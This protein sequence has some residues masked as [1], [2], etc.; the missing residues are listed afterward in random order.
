MPRLLFSSTV[1]L[2]C[3]GT[4]VTYSLADDRS[5]KLDIDYSEIAKKSTMLLSD[6]G[7][8]GVSPVAKD[9]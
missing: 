2:V 4:V 3:N 6:E 8:F 9:E 7:S 5:N 1:V